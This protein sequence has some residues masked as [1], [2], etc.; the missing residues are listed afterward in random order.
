MIAC[1]L[2]VAGIAGI[3]A[4]NGCDHVRDDNIFDYGIVEQTEII[5]HTN[6]IRGIHHS[7]LF[8][9]RGISVHVRR[10]VR[11]E[12]ASVVIELEERIF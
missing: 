6:V 10:Y 9:Y 8:G 4:R 5:F 3:F 11:L 7:H 12:G 1:A 2:Q